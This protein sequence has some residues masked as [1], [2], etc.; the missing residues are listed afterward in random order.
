MCSSCMVSSK[1]CEAERSYGTLNAWSLKAWGQGIFECAVWG[2]AV[3]A[4]WENKDLFVQGWLL[5]GSR[6]TGTGREWA[7]KESETPQD[8]AGCLT[9][10]ERR[11]RRFCWRFEY[12]F[13]TSISL[14]IS[15]YSMI[16]VVLGI[17]EVLSVLR[18]LI[19]QAFWEISLCWPSNAKN[20][21]S[22]FCMASRKYYSA[23]VMN[24]VKHQ[25]SFM[26]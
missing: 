10:S 17:S 14:E 26:L 12:I 11:P 15:C 2:T 13:V 20:T 5:T 7:G 1:Y 4:P 9:G 25:W 8:L 18:I 21:I 24:E 6:A 22:V 23:F 19:W 3:G 16:S